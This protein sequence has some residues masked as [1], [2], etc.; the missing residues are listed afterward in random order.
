MEVLCFQLLPVTAP[1]VGRVNQQK[2]T[3]ILY[4]AQPD[5][6]EMGE[7]GN[8]DDRISVK[9]EVETSYR[10]FEESSH[11]VMPR[12][13]KVDDRGVLVAVSTNTDDSEVVIKVEKPDLTS[14]TETEECANDFRHITDPSKAIIQTTTIGPSG[15]SEPKMTVG[16]T[17][18]FFDSMTVGDN[19]TVGDTMTVGGSVT[20][21][22][23]VVIVDKVTFRYNIGVQKYK[24]TMCGI[25][26]P[27]SRMETV[28]IDVTPYVCIACSK[29][30]T[31]MSVVVAHRRTLLGG[32]PFQCGELL[33][34][35]DALRVYERQQHTKGYACGVCGREF[36]QLQGLR[37]HGRTHAGKV[38]THQRVHDRQHTRAKGYACGVCGKE[39]TQLRGLRCHG[40]THAG[41]VETH[42]C[43]RCGK[44]FRRRSY[45][46]AHEERRNC[47]GPFTCVACGKIFRYSGSLFMHTRERKCRA[48]AM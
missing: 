24:C 6:A 39:F 33:A 43:D 18:N 1:G 5:S 10:S 4:L 17:V 28:A 35:A 25:A 45:L 41:K 46:K 47:Y 27:R 32:K 3:T 29:S 21:N 34:S 38:E 23:M 26:F 8:G 22:D 11:A 40:R 16:D 30:C 9:A 12:R 14:E 19:S 36:T 2:D 31:Q 7:P 20:I 13:W 37:C 48:V 15:R 44:T 42:Q